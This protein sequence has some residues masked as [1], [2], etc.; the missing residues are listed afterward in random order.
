MRCFPWLHGVGRVCE[1]R[2]G[3]DLRFFSARF[4]QLQNS[5]ELR[6]LCWANISA[7][8]RTDV[9]SDAHHWG[10]KQDH[11][12]KVVGLLS[13]NLKTYDEVSSLSIPTA[14]TA[15]TESRRTIAQGVSLKS[16]TTK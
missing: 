14:C 11:F 7:A 1:S 6:V 16:S 5:V 2:V 10:D 15:S 9:N 8:T 12:V 3:D 4:F 13:R